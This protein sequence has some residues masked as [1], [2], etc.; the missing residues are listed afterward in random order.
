LYSSPSSSL[1]QTPQ[2]PI[3]SCYITSPA[4]REAAEIAAEFPFEH[5][6]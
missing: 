2:I 5:A 6:V 1:L 4:R 3:V